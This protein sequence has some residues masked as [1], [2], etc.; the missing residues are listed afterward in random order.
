[1]RCRSLKQLVVLVA[2]IAAVVV[3][4]A[5][6][7][8]TPLGLLRLD[9]LD[10]TGG[11]TVG[12]TYI[13]W[14]PPAGGVGVGTGSFQVGFG[15]TLTSALGNPAPGS[16]GTLRDLG[17]GTPL[18]VSNFMTFTTVA[19]LAFD[20]LQVGPGSANTNC[21]GLALHE[22]CSIFAGSPIVL[23]LTPGGTSVSLSASGIARDGT[24]NSNWKGDFTTQIA[25]LTPAQIQ[26]SFGCASIANSQPQNCTNPGNTVSSTFSGEFVATATVP[27]P[28]SLGLLSL[29][30][31]TLA[32]YRR[33]RQ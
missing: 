30:L 31:V 17:P 28:A 24:T 19:G 27:E 20:L 4:V 8:A 14:T 22:T 6:A 1:M 21:A 32:A 26:A 10:G 12:F 23:Q 25:G 33:K 16:M 29:G 7:S 11:V 9:S 15:T 13:D 5:D 3:F 2:V 18:P